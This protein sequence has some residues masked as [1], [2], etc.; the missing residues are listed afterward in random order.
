MALGVA[1][2]AP[3]LLIPSGRSRWAQLCTSLE[4]VELPSSHSWTVSSRWI[5]AQS[6]EGNRTP[7]VG[8]PALTQKIL[9]VNYKMRGPV[10]W[11]SL[12]FPL[13]KVGMISHTRLGGV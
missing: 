8:A 7:V 13:C 6:A 11:W 9:A 4:D 12:R 10:T 2:A 5:R 1:D 3:A